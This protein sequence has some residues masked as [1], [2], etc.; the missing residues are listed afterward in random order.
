[1]PFGFD[2]LGHQLVKNSTEQ[3][4]IRMMRQYR[5]GGL[6]L[7]KIAG[8]LNLKLVPTKQNG[9]WQANTVREILARA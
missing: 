3:D 4:A 9:I 6:S 2:Y 8:N 7:R 1:L 5:S